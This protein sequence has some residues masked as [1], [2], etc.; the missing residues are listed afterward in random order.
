M[1]ELWV[2]GFPGFWGGADTELDHQIDLLRRC[3]VAVH[4]VP[5]FA[6]DPAAQRS[7]IERGCI[8]HPYADDVFADRVVVSFCNRNFLP[9]LARI[10]AAG[11]PARVVW[12]NCMT[13]PYHGLLDAHAAGWIDDYGFVSAYQRACLL[14]ALEAVAPVRTFAY[15]PYFNLE[16][17]A[18]RYRAWDG[19]YRIGRISRDDA[20]KFA[21]DTWRTFNRVLVPP[22]LRKEVRVLGF[23]ERARAAIGLPPA[24]LDVRSWPCNAS[25]TTVF[26]RGLDTMIHKTGT[27]RESYCRVL[28][29]AYAHGVVPIVEADFAFPELVVPGETGFMTSDSDEMSYLASVLAH[30]P[31]LHRRMAEQGRAHLERALVDADACWRGWL[32]ILES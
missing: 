14:P 21:P 27:S 16:R 1:R 8:V 26:F 18:W 9:S 22:G 15:R 7:A 2:A 13:W 30:E 19:S 11:P 31:R 32:E 24:G 29:E 17:I 10:M 20:S 3:G 4:L 12:L 25:D 5:M 23:G 6:A 28:V